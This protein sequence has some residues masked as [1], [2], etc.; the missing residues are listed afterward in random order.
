MRKLS[1]SFPDDLVASIDR[2]R[3]DTSRNRFVRDLLE[4]SLGDLREREYRRLAMEAYGDP[5]FAKEEEEIAEQFFGA[6]PEGEL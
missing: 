2:A 1:F 6:A 5:S 4:E 3:G